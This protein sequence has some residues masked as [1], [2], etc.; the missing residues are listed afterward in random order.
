[1]LTLR[2]VFRLAFRQT[3]GLIG[4][5]IGLLGLTLRVPDHTSLSRRAATLEVPQAQRR[6]RPGADRDA[7]P[8]H[9]LVDSTGLKLCGAGEWLLEKY[10]TQT[11]RFWRKLHLGVDARTGQILA[12]SLTPHDPEDA[13]QISPLL[14]Q[15]AGPVAS[16]TGDGAYDQAGV[17]TDVAADHPEAAVI[18]PPRSTAVRSKTADTDPTQRDRHLQCLA[19]TGRMGWQKVSGYPRRAKAE[20]AIARW[21]RVIGDGLR[22]RQDRQRTTEMKVAVHVLNHMLTL[23][24]PSYVRIS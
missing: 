7:E 3:E 5:I 6:V 13:S 15:V 4:S 2:T 10:G 21:K 23:G 18:V 14:D 1:M 11:R 9:L 8:L 24:R 20:T 17:Y 16:V 22:A 12:S 19:E